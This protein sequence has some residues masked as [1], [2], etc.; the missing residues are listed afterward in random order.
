[1]RRLSGVLFTML[2]FA[3][4]VWATEIRTYTGSATFNN[5]LHVS[6]TT[7]RDGNV[8]ARVQWVPKQGTQ[9]ALQLKRLA[10]PNDTFSYTHLCQ[11]YTG[12]TAPMPPP[13]GDWSCTIINGPAGFYS[14]DFFPTSGKTN[15]VVITVTAET[16]E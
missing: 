5:P 8:I 4:V 2:V 15:N 11:V 16:D 12:Q 14:V 9:Y 1:M 10:D 7:L 13:P 3:L 6:F